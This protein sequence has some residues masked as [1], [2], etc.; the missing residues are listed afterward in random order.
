L[1]EFLQGCF[2]ENFQ[3][4]FSVNSPGEILEL[5]SDGN[6]TVYTADDAFIKIRIEIFHD[7]ILKNV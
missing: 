6:R 7:P 2:A 1:L 4:S 5:V 3:N